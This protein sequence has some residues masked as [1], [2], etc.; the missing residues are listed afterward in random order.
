MILY[1]PFYLFSFSSF[2]LFSSF[3][4]FSA[5][6]QSNRTHPTDYQNKLAPAFCPGVEVFWQLDLNQINK[7]INRCTHHGIRDYRTTTEPLASGSTGFGPWIAAWYHKLWFMN[8]DAYNSK[9]S[10][11]R[12][13]FFI[14]VFIFFSFAIWTSF[15]SI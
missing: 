7:K 9:N 2:C 10:K 14:I 8:H 4:F 5:V 1:H 13:E 15:L 11:I 3:C 12:P 6:L